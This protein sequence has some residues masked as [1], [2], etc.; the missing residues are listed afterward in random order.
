MKKHSILSDTVYEKAKKLLNDGK[1]GVSHHKALAVA[2]YD[3]LEDIHGGKDWGEFARMIDRRVCI[4]VVLETV[5]PDFTLEESK[6]VK[7]N[8]WK[9]V[10]PGR[11][12]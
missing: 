10:N 3:V 11:W 8:E 6:K 12:D 9:D 4:E 7:T 5:A 2:L 1:C